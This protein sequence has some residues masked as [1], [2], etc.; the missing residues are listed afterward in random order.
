MFQPGLSP[1][2]RIQDGD[3]ITLMVTA[4]C[5]GIVS[6]RQLLFRAE[7][8][9]MKLAYSDTENID[10]AGS[11]VHERSARPGYGSD[12]IQRPSPGL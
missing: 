3:S 5:M 10:K 2:D 6:S 9:G 1:P 7:G 11:Y 4:L 8:R 12:D